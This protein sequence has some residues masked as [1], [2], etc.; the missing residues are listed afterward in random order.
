MTLK[1]CRAK[2]RRA[3]V[4][5]DTIEREVTA[6]LKN[7]PYRVTIERPTEHQFIVRSDD[8]PA[9][10]TDDWAVIIGDCVHN[11]R[12]SLDYIAWEL[13]GSDIGDTKTQ[14]PITI[15][16]GGWRRIVER[17]RISRIQPRRAR[18]LIKF[19]QPYRAGN[20]KETALNGLRVLDDT[21]KHKLLTVTAAVLH[22]MRVNWMRDT[23]TRPLY[24]IQFF[25]KNGLAHK[26]VLAAI[27][28][29]NPSPYME[30]QVEIAPAIVFGDAVG[31]ERRTEV[32][33]SLRAIIS[34]VESTTDLFNRCFFVTVQPSASC[35][36]Q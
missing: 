7:H 25:P 11:L 9:V 36:Q 4:H 15:S 6:F 21:D 18:A 28:V 2:I 31:L 29:S 16:Y 27:K 19:L 5:F 17:G 10:P 30:M 14:F 34:E 23:P 24:E 13:A 32:L 12:A 35:W 26:A 33:S 3:K 22:H 8:P 1:G 20:P